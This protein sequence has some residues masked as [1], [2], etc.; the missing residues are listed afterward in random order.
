[1]ARPKAARKAKKRT[2]RKATAVQGAPANKN[3]VMAFGTPVIAYPWPDSDALNK[4]LAELILARESESEGMARSNFGGWHSELDFLNWG[5][6]CIETLKERIKEMTIDLTRAITVAKQGTRSFKYRLSG[7]ANVSRNG[8]YNGVHNHPNCLWSGTYYVQPGKPAEGHP[9]NGKL[10]LLDPRAGIQLIHMEG[11]V[12]SG[13]YVVDPL[14]G[15]MIMFP[16]WLNHMVHPFFG[17]G[18]RISIA[19]NVLTKEAFNVLTKEDKS[20]AG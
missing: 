11:T 9:N 17:D 19:F 8:D 13:R 16:A 14:P 10:E 7:W 6:P 2:P 15:L 1:M 20:R 18:E 4:E 5:S 12:L 3:M